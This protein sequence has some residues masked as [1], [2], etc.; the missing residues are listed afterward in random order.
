MMNYGPIRV[1]INLIFKKIAPN[2]WDYFFGRAAPRECYGRR[3]G[4]IGV[5]FAGRA[6]L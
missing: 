1:L 4:T 3:G 2:F 5:T 6:E